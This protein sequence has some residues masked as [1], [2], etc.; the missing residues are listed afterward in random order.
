MDRKKGRLDSAEE[1]RPILD[2]AEKEKAK[3]KEN[4]EIMMDDFGKNYEDEQNA[5]PAA[6]KKMVK[7][8]KKKLENPLE[9]AKMDMLQ[10]SQIQRKGD[11][12]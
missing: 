7:T 6:T 8:E 5:S 4:V 3:T 10:K 11:E 1:I 12:E 9:N 2:E